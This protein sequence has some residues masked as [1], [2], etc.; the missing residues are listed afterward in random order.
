MSCD[1]R[2]RHSLFVAGIRPRVKLRGVDEDATVH[3]QAQTVTAGAVWNDVS[4]G[5]GEMLGL[6]IWM[7]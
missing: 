5:D 4:Y 1:L 3:R 2:D 6:V 7:R